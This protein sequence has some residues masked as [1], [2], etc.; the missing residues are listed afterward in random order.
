[1]LNF[2]MVME[3]ERAMQPQVAER[4]KHTILEVLSEEEDDWREHY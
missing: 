2:K 1:M 4:S 3:L